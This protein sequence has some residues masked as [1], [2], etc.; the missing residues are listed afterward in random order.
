MTATSIH[1]DTTDR[2]QDEAA[3]RPRF[4]GV[5]WRIARSTNRLTM[6]LAGKGW[7]P[8]FAFVEHQGRR[9][10]RRYATPIAARRIPGGFVISLAFGA[11]VDWYRNLVA[12]RGGTV[13]WRGR[14]YRVTAPEIIDSSTALAA[15][16]PVQRWLLR[17]ADIG[18]YVRV[19]DVDSR[20][21]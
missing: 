6:P 1:T 18:G 12:A 11:Q 19:A 21:R 9:T 15:F 10:G 14:A 8:I 7:N 13:R 2:R 5:L 16:H 4:G 3:P 17:I 20:D